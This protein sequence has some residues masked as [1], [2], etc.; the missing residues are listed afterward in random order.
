MGE[1]LWGKTREMQ[2]ETDYMRVRW[3]KNGNI[4]VEIKK[5][6]LIERINRIIAKHFGETV[7]DEAA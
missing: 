4:D 1:H 7:A 5:P 2:V 3:F 6:E